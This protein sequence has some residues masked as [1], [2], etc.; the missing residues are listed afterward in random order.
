[1]SSKGLCFC[2]FLQ[3]PESSREAHNNIITRDEVRY[4]HFMKG[5]FHNILKNEVERILL[6][7]FRMSGHLCGSNNMTEKHLALVKGNFLP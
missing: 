1:M 4:L 7:M 6:S 3:E 2:T 5:G